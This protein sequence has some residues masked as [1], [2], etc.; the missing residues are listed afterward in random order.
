MHLKNKKGFTLMEV[1][2]VVAIISILAGMLT[3]ALSRAREKAREA[4][5]KNNLKQLG[6]L[7][8]LY[9][10]DNDENFP[11]TLTA[12]S[13]QDLVSDDDLSDLISIPGETTAIS[14]TQP[15]TVSDDGEIMLE[16]TY[17]STLF[18][19]TEN[20]GLKKTTTTTTTSSS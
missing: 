1:L 13:T 20:Y 11:S 7:V 16:A 14:Y 12:L 4:E 9:Q 18:Y 15:S 10:L 17:G 19:L 2:V 8:S 6:Y 3:P 5:I